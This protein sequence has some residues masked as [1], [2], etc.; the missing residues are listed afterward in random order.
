VLR[1]KNYPAALAQ[2]YNAFIERGHVLEN[3]YGKT[4]TQIAALN[5]GGVDTSAVAM[6]AV[7][8]RT[9][10]D[11]R[12]LFVEMGRL[13]A[14]GRQ[15]LADDSFGNL[16]TDIVG[17]AVKAFAI[18]GDTTGTTELMG[19]AKGLAGFASKGHA[20]AE[21]LSAQAGK[22]ADAIDQLQRTVFEYQTAYAQLL[23]TVQAKYPDQDWGFMAPKQPV[24][25]T[26]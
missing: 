7:R 12:E 20:D 15:R 11:R 14:L 26:Q 2:Y 10:G 19:A 25:A 21:A 6:V 16:V 22:V 17:A 4:L 23:T 1:R 9:I 13:A 5:G 18:T 3:L 24:S 8:E